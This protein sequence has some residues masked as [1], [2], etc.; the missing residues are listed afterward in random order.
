[1][2]TVTFLPRRKGYHLGM[3]RDESRAR[4]GGLPPARTVLDRREYLSPSEPGGGTW[5]CLND[6]GV[7]LSL[8]NWYAVTKRVPRSPVSR[9]RVIR[10]SQSAHSP[11]LVRKAL[12]EMPLH[13]I[14]PFRLIGVFPVEQCILEWRWNLEN[15]VTKPHAWTPR[16]WVSSGFD[17]PEAQRVR[18]RIFQQ[19]RGQASFGTLDWL[20]RLHRSHRPVAGPFSTCM[21]RE[22]AVTVSYT[23]VSVVGGRGVMRYHDGAPCGH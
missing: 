11:S 12:S 8:I 16:Q 7:C 23:E 15:L 3:N 10:T 17:E 13:R 19:A 9:G 2:C 18:R 22:D 5:I 1:M 20:R 21:H 6:A 14:N 4:I